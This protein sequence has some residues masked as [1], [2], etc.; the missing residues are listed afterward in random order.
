MKKLLAILLFASSY[1]FLLSVAQTHRMI[2]GLL[3]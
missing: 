1:Y 3:R 2:N